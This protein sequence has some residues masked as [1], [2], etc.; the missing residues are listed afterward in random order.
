VCPQVASKA[1][2]CPAN[3]STMIAYTKVANAPERVVRDRA[4][5]KVNPT[6]KPNRSMRLNYAAALFAI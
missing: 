5:S 6:P 3:A 4:P 1:I 2:L